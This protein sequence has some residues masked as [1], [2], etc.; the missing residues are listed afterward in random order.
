MPNIFT[1]LG[2]GPGYVHYGLEFNIPRKTKTTRTNTRTVTATTHYYG[3]GECIYFNSKFYMVVWYIR[4]KEDQSNFKMCDVI[5]DDPLT[6]A[7]LQQKLYCSFWNSMYVIMFH[8]EMMMLLSQREV[9]NEKFSTKKK[10]ESKKKFVVFFLLP[11]VSFCCWLGWDEGFVLL[12]LYFFCSSDFS[13]PK[14]FLLEQSFC[15]TLPFHFP[16]KPKF[17][18]CHANKIKGK[19][20]IWQEGYFRFGCFSQTKELSDFIRVIFRLHDNESLNP[21]SFTLKTS[22][23]CTS[24]LLQ[25]K[26]YLSNYF[27][28]LSLRS[29]FQVW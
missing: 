17:F 7:V 28:S 6:E 24:T 1:R 9:I 3:K 16:K 15:L 2:P 25:K 12:L 11:E 13:T 23:K 14:M 19:V 20:C 10:E 5:T 4:E 27:S 26:L 22:F 21:W 18:F 8:N 29:N